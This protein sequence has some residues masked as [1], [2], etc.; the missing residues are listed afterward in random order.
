MPSTTEPPLDTHAAALALVIQDIKAQHPTLPILLPSDPSFAALAACY[1]M[2]PGEVVTTT[3]TAPTCLAL[4]RPR[5][6]AEV[7]A[8]VA[9]C[10]ARRLPIVVRAGAHDTAGRTRVPGALAIDLREI[11]HVH[12]DEDEDD[13]VGG[14]A[15]LGIS[16][17]EHEQ[18][19]K[20]H[21][22][23]ARVGGGCLI[24]GVLAELER[25]GLATPVGTISTVGYVGWAYVGG[26]GPLSSLFGPGV[27]QI[28]G[29]T[30][31]TAAGEVVEADGALLRG[32]RGA[33]GALGVVVEVT[34]KVYPLG[35]VS[36]LFPLLWGGG[37]RLGISLL[38]R[39]R[40][41]L[42]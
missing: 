3:T 20:K 4:A 41:W 8:V 38:Q 22:R 30:L 32:V 28:V 10:A 17:H 1:I 14:G 13:G 12:V 19:Q 33:A 39:L 29:A 40:R 35:R 7:G 11:C 26:Y 25:H 23:T 2:V 16:E 15:S 37:A 42:G 18:Q 21:Q 6:A 34:V 31:V 5:S 9:A 27:D 36:V 24:A